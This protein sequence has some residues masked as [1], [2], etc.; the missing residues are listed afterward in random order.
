MLKNVHPGTDLKIERKINGQWIDLQ[1]VNINR[2]DYYQGYFNASMSMDYAFSLKRPSANLEEGWTIRILG[3]MSD[4]E[5][6]QSGYRDLLENDLDQDKDQVHL[7]LEYVLNGNPLEENRA[8]LPSIEITG[9]DV[10]YV[11]HRRA[12]SADSFEQVFQYSADLK[13]WSKLNITDNPAEGVTIETLVNGLEKVTIAMQ[14]SGVYGR[15][16]VTQLP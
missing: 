1:G 5:K 6:W 12:E 7:F 11:F 16:K 4:F 15:I 14:Q 10:S 2:H 9:D 8:I 13:N 3:S